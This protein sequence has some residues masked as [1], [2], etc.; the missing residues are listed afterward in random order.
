MKLALSKRRAKQLAAGTVFYSDV[1]GMWYLSLYMVVDGKAA[2]FGMTPH[3]TEEAALAEG[4]ETLK[5][6]DSDWIE[7]DEEAVESYIAEHARHRWNP[8]GE[9]V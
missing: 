9:D 4:N 3:E 5:V 7:I 6:A 1:L 2:P 8:S